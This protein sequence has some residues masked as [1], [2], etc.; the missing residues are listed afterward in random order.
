MLDTCNMSL[1]GPLAMELRAATTEGV[2]GG[3][4]TCSDWVAQA[5]AEMGNMNIYDVRAVVVCRQTTV[6]CLTM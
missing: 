4:E 1:I 3:D 2:Q 6:L 5:Q